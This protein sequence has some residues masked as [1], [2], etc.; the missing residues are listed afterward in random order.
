MIIAGRFHRMNLLWKITPM[1][2]LVSLVDMCSYYCLVCRNQTWLAQSLHRDA[3]SMSIDAQVL[4]LEHCV[5]S[6][7]CLDYLKISLHWKKQIKV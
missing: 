1:E 5:K 4:A 7:L 6:I 2:E 3:S